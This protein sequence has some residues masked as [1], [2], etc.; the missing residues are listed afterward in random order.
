MIGK[1]PNGGLHVDRRQAIIGALVGMLLAS[2]ASAASAQ[3]KLT[4]MVFPGLSNLPLYA[5]QSKGFFAQRN[6]DVDIKFA[7]GSAELR[8]GLAEGRYQIVH[9]AVDNAVAM[10]EAAKV[11]AAIVI[12]GDNGF[13][14]LFVS[15]E[16][17][18]YA[19]IRGKTVLVDATNTA[20]A[21]FLYAMLKQ[22]GLGKDDYVVKSVGATAF[23]LAGLKDGTGVAAMLNPPFSIVG[24]REGLK[25]FGDATKALGPI[26]ATGGFV[27]R[28]WA[29][30]NAD[31]LVRYL[32]AYIDGLRWARD[33]AN[34]SEAIAFYVERLKLPQDVA[35]E[36]YEVAVGADHGLAKDGQ[37]DVAGF[38]NILKLRTTFEGGS[39]LSPE[40]FLDLTYYERALSGM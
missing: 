26:Q 24:K 27:L 12:G 15:P 8:N 4:I 11:D 33:P 40:T 31:T 30:A 20:Y 38:R 16:I 19:D 13:Q 36:C 1:Q 2:L 9:S 23:R 28:S 34:K 29:K 17:G 35:A 6:L 18:S 14:Q 39:E 37:F 5:A 3:T 32:Q 25:D 10:V 21:F 7:P 22:N